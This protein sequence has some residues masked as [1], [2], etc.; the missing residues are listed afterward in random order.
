MKL[1]FTRKTW[2]FFLLC[3]GGGI[4]AQRLCRA[5]RHGFFFAGDGGVLHH[6]HH[7]R[8]FWPLKRALTAKDKRNYFLACSWC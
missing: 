5:G 2:Y 4:H 8:C 7:H 1:K 6:R 3:R